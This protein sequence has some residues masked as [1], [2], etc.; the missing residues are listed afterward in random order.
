MTI[1]YAAARSAPLL[2]W[3]EERLLIEGWQERRDSS[4][5]ERLLLSHARIVYFW[6][7]KVTRDRTEQ[8]ELVA[9]GIMGLIKAANVFD[10]AQRVRFATYAKWWVKNSVITSFARLR[11][12]VEVPASSGT[13]FDRVDDA[14]IDQLASQ[15]PTPEE[16]TIKNATRDELTRHLATALDALDPVDRQI[17]HARCISQPP[18]STAELAEELCV[19][20]A[21]VR[22]IERRALSRLKCELVNQGVF[23]SRVH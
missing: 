16:Q 4:A 13:G 19:G 10:L 2:R 14:Q 6:A 20:K 1:T 18:V 3:E 12:I 21:K 5:L 23:T 11:S 8:E 9:E 15:D 17:L 22:Q 7:R